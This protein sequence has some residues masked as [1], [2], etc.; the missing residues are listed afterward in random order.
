MAK[1]GTRDH[2]WEVIKANIRKAGVIQQSTDYISS[3]T[4]SRDRNEFRAG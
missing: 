3:I 4:S 2:S 1:C